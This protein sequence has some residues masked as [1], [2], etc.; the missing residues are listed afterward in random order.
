MLEISRLAFR[1]DLILIILIN[2]DD[3]LINDLQIW[4]GLSG[5]M[6]LWSKLLN[7]QPCQL[8]QAGVGGW[9]SKI[10]TVA[11]RPSRL[12]RVVCR[13]PKLAQLCAGWRKILKVRIGYDW[14]MLHDL[15]CWYL[16]LRF[17]RLADS[18][19]SDDL[20]LAGAVTSAVVC[21]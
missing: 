21:Q 18:F 2:L 3:P 7:L 17:L 14:H 12:V 15:S 10:F 9:T 1:F 11:S 5:S 4:D 16:M 6:A 19:E 20:N 13:D 8:S